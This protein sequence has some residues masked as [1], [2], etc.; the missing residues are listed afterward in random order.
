MYA[1]GNTKTQR[2]KGTEARE[3]KFLS[4]RFFAFVPLVSLCFLYGD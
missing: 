2:H 4:A 1:S 3:K